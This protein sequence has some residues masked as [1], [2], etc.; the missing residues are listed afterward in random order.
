MGW[1]IEYPLT[2]PKSCAGRNL[3]D[4]E[5]EISPVCYLSRNNYDS[6]LSPNG[7]LFKYER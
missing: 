6:H 2:L 3:G 1:T 4:L 7:A 5:A